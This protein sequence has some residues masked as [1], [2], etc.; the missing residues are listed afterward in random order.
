MPGSGG[1]HNIGTEVAVFQAEEMLDI[2]P[3]GNFE[4]LC[5]W[6]QGPSVSPCAK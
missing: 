2:A 4:G 6:V 3:P 1:D 5:Y